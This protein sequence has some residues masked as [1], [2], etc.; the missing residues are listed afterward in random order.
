MQPKKRQKVFGRA[1]AVQRLAQWH[2]TAWEAETT[3]GEST[4]SC[5]ALDVWCSQKAV[6]HFFFFPFV[7]LF[8][9]KQHRGELVLSMPSCRHVQKS[10]AVVLLNACSLTLLW[11]LFWRFTPPS[12]TH[13]RSEWWLPTPISYITHNLWG[14]IHKQLWK[15]KCLNLGYS[16]IIFITNYMSS[17]VSWH[18]KL[19]ILLFI[20]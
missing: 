17:L 12:K 13:I 15:C 11:L 2:T 3:R 8:A 4:W 6:F 20:A 7:C 1:V 10:T 9:C 16:V 14:Q 5:R 19:R 18:L